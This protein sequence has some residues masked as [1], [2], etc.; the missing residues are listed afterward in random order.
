MKRLC[1]FLFILIL[2]I[3]C[4]SAGEGMWLPMLL[5]KYNIEEMQ[6]KGFRLTQKI[7]T[8]LTRPA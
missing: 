4:T 1:L 6:Q 2:F 7:F 3:P 5:E 8:V